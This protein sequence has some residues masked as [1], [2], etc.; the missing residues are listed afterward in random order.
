LLSIS[1]LENQIVFCG[2]IST[3]YKS[4]LA[5]TL[6]E[7]SSPGK[8]KILSTESLS[9][10]WP[11]A[12]CK[13]DEDKENNPC[14]VC[15]SFFS[16]AHLLQHAEAQAKDE[17]PFACAICN[18][19]FAQAARLEQH[20]RAHHK[21]RKSV[22]DPE[23]MFQEHF[24][25]QLSQGASSF[26]ASDKSFQHK[27]LHKEHMNTQPDEHRE[28]QLGDKIPYEC[29][30][31]DKSFATEGRFRLHM[32]THANEASSR[33]DDKI[34]AQQNN[35]NLTEQ[36]NIDAVESAPVVVIDEFT[37]ADT[38]DMEE[39]LDV[40]SD[41]KSLQQTDNDD[42]ARYVCS[43]CDKTF[44]FRN[45]LRRHMLFHTGQKKRYQCALCPKSY[46]QN[47]DLKRHSSS[48][49]SADDGQVN[50]EYACPTCGKTFVTRSNMR[51]HRIIHTGE[52]PYSCPVCFKAFTQRTDMKKHLRLHTGDSGKHSN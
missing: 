32:N 12:H 7:V 3:Q 37:S 43:V 38:S 4:A 30:K 39:D 6:L 26:S 21:K 48:V 1:E 5:F 23:Q 25:A 14:S 27:T 41:E 19:T 9:F 2:K 24:L 11:N 49:H 45:S 40:S 47:G 31:C 33:S 16:Q 36:K 52:R 18:Q 20:V 13:S 51:R 15:S 17:K 29:P 35:K 42:A 10:S 22:F 46:S 8:M 28:I 44:T 34:S 50:P